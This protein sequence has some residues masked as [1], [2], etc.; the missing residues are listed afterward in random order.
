VPPHLFGMLPGD[1]AAH[2]R[3]LGVAVT[4]GEARRV[5]AHVLSDGRPGF[6]DRRPVAARVTDAIAATT[7][8]APLEVLERAEDPLDGFVKYLLRSP[9]GALSEA[10]R[11]PLEKPGTF[12]ACLST[13]VGCAMGCAFCATGRLGLSRN[14]AAWEMVAAFLAVR[15]DAPGR[16]AG[17][18]FQGQGEPLA[19]YDAVI[20]AARVLQDPCG[21]RIRA[22]N[23][24][25]STV[26]LV[27]AIRRYAREGHPYR[28]I[29]S[30]TST[31]PARRAAL[32]PEAA[33]F[34]LADLAAALREYAAACGDRVTVAWVTIAGVNT[35]DDEVEGLARLLGDLPLRVNLIEVN[36]PR[37]GGFRPPDLAELDRFRAALKDR[38]WPVVRRY[39]G[40]VRAHAACGML[41]SRRMA[42]EAL[43]G[44][45]GGPSGK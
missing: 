26:G 45:G 31:D 29:V 32:L 24:S 17:A 11:I 27:P 43:P 18:V 7:D 28:L 8:R 36:D 41:A 35:G 21:G 42:G 39:S 38:G 15:A 2:L 23:I 20:R 33:R 19:N 5:M 6:P 1:L 40:G 13:Q 22:E 9:D 25:I 10:V 4:E 30:L 44:E 37:E 12:S 34:D 16:V 14:L 3:G